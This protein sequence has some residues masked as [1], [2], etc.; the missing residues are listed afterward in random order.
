MLW[1][2]WCFN[3][4]NDWILRFVDLAFLVL[5]VFVLA[6]FF[7]TYAARRYFLFTITS[8]IFPIQGIL[9][10]V[11]RNNRGMNY[12]EFIRGEQER[13][14]RMYQQYR[15]QNFD[16][17]PYNQ[18]PYSRNGYDNGNVY[19]GPSSDGGADPFNE[20]GGNNPPDDPFDDLNGNKH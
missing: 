8:I 13:Q 16:G 12:G 17:N 5:Q 7:Q 11:L 1:A 20:Y 10:F 19:G 4:L 6:A 15:Q 3:Y 18:N 2:S 9:F 14:Y